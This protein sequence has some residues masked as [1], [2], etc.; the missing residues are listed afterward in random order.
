MSGFESWPTPI[1]RRWLLSTA[2]GPVI[3]LIG[4]AGRIVLHD[5]T[6]LTLSILL[7]GCIVARCI[8]LFRTIRQGAYET[9]E[10][11][12]VAIRRAPLG[13]HQRIR[14]VDDSD[15]AHDLL[16]DR[17]QKFLIGSSYRVYLQS[18]PGAALP[19]AR[20]PHGT[21]LGL[22]ELGACRAESEIDGQSA[23]PE[24]PNIIDMEEFNEQ[25]SQKSYPSNPCKK[26]MT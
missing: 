18:P 3:F 5:P 22:E 26:T 8:L 9:V 13:G 14:L 7:S 21:L 10:G 12:C 4:L 19:E 6:L 20:I 24:D 11:V 23:A 17:R 2:A 1:L 16:L 15:T 25:A